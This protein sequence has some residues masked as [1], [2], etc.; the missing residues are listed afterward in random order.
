MKQG[1]ARDLAQLRAITQK[2]KGAS[3]MAQEDIE[4]ALQLVTRLLETLARD[5]DQTEYTATATQNAL[6]RYGMR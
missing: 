5:V 3:P 2:P 4:E 6:R 1:I